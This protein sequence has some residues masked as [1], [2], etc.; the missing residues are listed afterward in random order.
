MGTKAR[1]DHGEEIASLVSILEVLV[2]LLQ[3]S[4]IFIMLQRSA[5]TP[6]TIVFP[7]LLPWPTVSKCY[8]ARKKVLE[9]MTKI[10]Q[11][12][13]KNAEHVRLYYSIY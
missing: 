9:V 12:H 4:L 5:A 7:F 3:M 1:I 11:S 2:N 8:F 13:P 10:Y 6:S